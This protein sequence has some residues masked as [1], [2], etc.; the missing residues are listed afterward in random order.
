[1]LAL[2]GAACAA[3]LIMLS[4]TCP[5]RFLCMGGWIIVFGFFMSVPR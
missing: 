4:Y 5:S 1:M 3:A 2:A